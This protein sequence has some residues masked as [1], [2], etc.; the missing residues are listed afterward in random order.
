[1]LQFL[2][3]PVIILLLSW[4]LHVLCGLRKLNRGGRNRNESSKPLVRGDVLVGEGGMERSIRSITTMILI[5]QV[6]H[7]TSSLL[8][9]IIFISQMGYFGFGGGGRV[10]LFVLFAVTPLWI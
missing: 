4:P 5:I 10:W 2:D 9:K 7:D 3:L 8:S 1:M 6:P